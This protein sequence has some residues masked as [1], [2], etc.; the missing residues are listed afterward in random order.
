MCDTSK[1]T[2]EFHRNIGRPDSL[3]HRCKACR[4]KYR[5]AR[6]KQSREYQRRWRAAKKRGAL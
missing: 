3:A 1:P 2:S 4:A 5:K 6:N